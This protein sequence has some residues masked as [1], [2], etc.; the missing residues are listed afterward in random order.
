M[1]SLVEISVLAAAKDPLIASRPH[2][3]QLPMELL[4]L[5]T[6][7]LA[8]V[9]RMTESYLQALTDDPAECQLE[10]VDLS[11]VGQD[12]YL[13]PISNW[14]GIRHIIL[15]RSFTLN[16]SAVAHLLKSLSD[17]GVEIETLSFDRC[18]RLGDNSL[19]L[20]PNLTSLTSLN[21]NGT[22]AGYYTIRSLTK[23]SNLRSLNLSC[24]RVGSSPI[25]HLMTSLTKLEVLNIPNTGFSDECIGWFQVENSGFRLE[26]LQHFDAS[27]NVHLTDEGVRDLLPRFPNIQSVILATNANITGEVYSILAD[28]CPL[29]T[30]LNLSGTNIEDIQG[31]Q[32]SRLCNLVTIDLSRGEAGDVTADSLG[33]IS[34]LEQIRMSYT[35]ISNYALI[36]FGNLPN[37]QSL[38]ICGCLNISAHALQHLNPDIKVLEIGGRGID[39]EAVA[40]LA[41]FQSIESLSLWETEM[42]DRG[43]EQLERI[44]GI[45]KDSK[46]QATKGTYILLR[47]D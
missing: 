43:C 10:A 18:K 37:L 24:L 28:G 4:E 36:Q 45:A 20:L 16:D 32:L 31:E 5:L 14:K 41:R 13:Y 38:K 23:I 29:V 30:H 12:G 6:Q 8:R 25:C 42:T 44:L 15:D 47:E 1:K 19:A 33:K 3:H 46:M 35:S 26:S 7:T 39:N 34:S 2:L 40:Y 11:G 17:T 22:R 21:L 9:G 27:F